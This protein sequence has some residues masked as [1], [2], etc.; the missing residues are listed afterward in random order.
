MS[1]DTASYIL[2]D[3][4]ACLH[5]TI[6]PSASRKAKI[7]FSNIWPAQERS[8]F[9]PCFLGQAFPTLFTKKH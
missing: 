3:S 4:N 7:V 9:F 1:M 6:K 2:M 8:T 5:T